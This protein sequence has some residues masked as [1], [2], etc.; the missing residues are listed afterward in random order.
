MLVR[1]NLLFYGYL[2]GGANWVGRSAV[3]PGSRLA[4]IWHEGGVCDES[5]I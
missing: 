4:E 5:S 3:G 2:V 1:G